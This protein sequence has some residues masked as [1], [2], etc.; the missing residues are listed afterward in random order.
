[1]T[2]S[3]MP[4]GPDAQHMLDPSST[5]VVIVIVTAVRTCGVYARGSRVTFK[6]EMSST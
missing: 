5:S 2:P 1:M 3:L 4:T 6:E